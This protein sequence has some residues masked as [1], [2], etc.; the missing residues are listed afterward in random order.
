M[1]RINANINPE[2]LIDQHLVAEYREII[3]IPNAVLKIRRTDAHRKYPD[4][5]VLGSG[6]VLYFYNKIKFLHKR[7]LSL[8]REMDRRAMANNIGDD[9]F[10]TFKDNVEYI[11]SY[12]DICHN[13]LLDANNMIVERILER[14]STMKRAPTINRERVDL[15]LYRRML[16][17]S[18]CQRYQANQD[19]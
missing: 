3:R 9:M 2:H 4:S 13:E 10:E 8:K 15:D 11:E 5:F 1:T 7:F 12:R 17:S 14:V 19:M 6:H 16:T 18:Y